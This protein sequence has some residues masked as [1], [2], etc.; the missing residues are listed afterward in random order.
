M[1]QRELAE[2]GEEE[3]WDLLF[4]RIRPMTKVKQTWCEKWL[5][6][7]ENGNSSDSSSEGEVGFTSDMGESTSDKGEDQQEEHP[8]QLEIK[9]VFTIPAEFY[10]PI[11][12]VV[13]L[14]LGAECAMF[15]KPDNLGEHMKP[16]FICGHLDG[17][18]IGYMLVDGGTSGSILP[19]LFKKLGHNES[20]LKHTNVSLSGFTGDPTEAKG[21]ICKELT[22]GSKTVPTAFFTVD[23][24]G[25]Y[26]VLL[27]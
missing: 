12:D 5:S 1:R 19:L 24:K 27:G 8:T 3:Q 17:T 16:L 9:M 6:R 2:K 25:H 23:M 13:E 11:E 21:I 4:N 18:P 22:V 14:T 7:E 20:D 15:E 26:N 10:A